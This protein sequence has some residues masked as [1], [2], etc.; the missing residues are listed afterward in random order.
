MKKY[1]YFLICIVFFIGSFHTSSAQI[2]ATYAGNG[3]AGYSGN[4]GDATLA[5][6]DTPTCVAQDPSG[7]IYINDQRNNCIRKVSPSGIIST[8]A[9]INT[10]GFA[11]DNGPA[12]AARMNANW[13]MN[14]DA[15]GNI[16]IC[17]QSNHRIRKV[18]TAGIITTIAGTGTGGYSGDGGPATAANIN[19]PMGIATDASGNV[20]F[21]DSYN[22]C[23]RKISTAGIISTIAGVPGLAGFSGDGGP[24]TA[25]RVKFIWGMNF[26]AAGNLY[27][28]D[29]PNDRVRMVNTSGI[30]NT[31]AGNGTSGF[32]GD[33]GAATAASLNKPLGVFVA[34]DG[35]IYIAD[36]DNNRVRQISTSGI[37]TTIAG[38]G[39][40]GYN[41]EGIPA[42]TAQMHHP[43]GVVVDA[44]DNVYFSDVRNARVRKVI[45]IL[46]FEKG[47]DE[48]LPVCENAISVPINDLLAV[49]DVYIGLTDVWS[50]HTP[51][52]HGAAIVGYAATSTGGVLTPSG[53]TYT[54]ATGYVGPDS[55]RVKVANTLAS[56]IITIYVTID[57]LLAPGPII[58]ASRLCLGDTTLLTNSL[59]GGIW[60]SVGGL[61]QVSPSLSYCIVKGLSPGLDTIRY[62]VT[63][64]CGS[65]DALKI[66]TVNPL[67]YPGTI[68][69]PAAL[70]LGSNVSFI[71]S[72][73]GGLWSASNLNISVAPSAPDKCIVSGAMQGIVTLA[74]SVSDTLCTAVVIKPLVVE[75]FPDAGTIIGP[76]S[77]CIGEQIFLSDSAAGGV[78]SADTGYVSVSNGLVTGI[79]EGEDIVRYSVTNTCGTDYAIRQVRVAPQPVMPD[80]VII[81]GV[82]Y[83]GVGYEKYQW[84]VN[85]ADISGATADTFYAAGQGVYQVIVTNQ[86]GC[87][88][89]SALYDNVGCSPDDIVLYPNPTL[90]KVK[91]VW[92]KKVTVRVITANGKEVSV[93]KD[94]NQVDL[95]GLPAGVYFLSMFDADG[96][97]LKTNK[98]VKM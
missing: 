52:A 31:I 6:L 89:A 87:S 96:S 84:R 21:S 55:F 49:R 14:V 3:L 23:I 30:I 20:Y 1:L 79:T 35:R 76:V 34:H 47:D 62:T 68:S 80:L 73:S 81:Q 56:D 44:N 15:A 5:Q 75:V 98:V 37:I 57:P 69:G 42:T 38:N 90:D 95:R 51:P 91:I 12:T 25:A 83:A 9:G 97:K 33:N 74:Y 40:A 70:C 60:S 65:V 8:V 7:N 39:I 94:V 64:A 22:F 27:L 71:A 32:A 67:P 82:L 17:D 41:G 36:C 48:L 58:G 77:V 19:S 86:Y 11:G 85:G 61:L 10:A 45:N 53:L 28:C 92:C 78:W 93:W 63:N 59:A 43:I 2:I 66:I 26:D 13:G 24:A 18:N 50:L 46:S 29:G 16:Y 54:P 88:V 72:V 4:G